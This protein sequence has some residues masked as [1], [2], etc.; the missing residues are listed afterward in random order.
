[1]KVELHGK[2]FK[3]IEE[4]KVLLRRYY[5]LTFIQTDKPI[6]TPGQ[7]GEL[8]IFEIWSSVNTDVV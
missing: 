8:F 4:R 1:M 3:M 2:T 7:T 6:Y 5:H